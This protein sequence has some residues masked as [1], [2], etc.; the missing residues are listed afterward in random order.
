[1]FIHTIVPSLS[2]G[3]AAL[4]RGYT[5]AFYGAE[6]P[7]LNPSDP[8]YRCYMLGWTEGSLARA[9]ASN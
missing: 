4:H 7:R 5:D 9:A 1:M 8:A 2:E 6:R 3:N